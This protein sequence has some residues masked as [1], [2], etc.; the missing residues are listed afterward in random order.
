MGDRRGALLVVVVVVIG[1]AAAGYLALRPDGLPRSETCDD[2]A[3]GDARLRSVAP[4][5][6]PTAEGAEGASPEPV[7]RPKEA[8]QV[9]CD[10]L[11]DP[12]V[13]AVDRPVGQRLFTFG[14]G[15]QAANV[16]VLVS[17]GLAR[18]EEVLDALPALPGWSS[19]GA[20]W[21]PSVLERGGRFFLYYTTR[22]AESGRQCISHAKSDRAE[23][24]Y[25]DTSTAPLVCPL[26]RGGAID[27]SPF[28]DPDGTAFLLWKADGNCCGLPV[29]LFAQELDAAGT[30]VVGEPAELLAPSQ[31]WEGGVVEAPV[32]VLRDGVHHLFYSANDWSGA[33]Y[34][35]GWAT[36][37]SVTGPCTKPLD[38]P[39]LAS[40]G[41]AVGP[42]GQ[43]VFADSGGDLHLVFHAWDAAAI[44]YDAGGFRRLYAV[45]LRFVDGRPV[46]S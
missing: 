18:S 20:V 35:I 23:G 4:D 10:D 41:E 14:T 15:T 40:S 32:M 27:P 34:A 5:A 39:W 46:T 30:A 2:V 22:H 43:E 45:G 12:F 42:G 3:P 21:A 24:P 26:E 44:G 11:A 9:Y 33:G 13:L 1:F 25:E 31:P 6:A 37:E 29:G 38:G 36:C 8:E 19:E 28:V 17:G 16:P 7:F